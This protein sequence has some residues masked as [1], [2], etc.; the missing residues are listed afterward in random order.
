MASAAYDIAVIGAGPAGMAAALYARIKR[1]ETVVISKDVGGQML[2]GPAIG[3][4]LGFEAI[5]SAELIMRMRTQMEAHGPTVV[6]GNAATKVER[7]GRGFIV[8]AGHDT[9]QVKAVII[10]TG[11]VPRRL[12][13]PGERELVGKG[14]TYCT[15]CDGPLFK[16]KQVAV[17]GSGMS[18]IYAALHLLRIASHV[19]LLS[20]YALMGEPHL[21][22]DLGK[23]ANVTVIESAQVTSIN[24]DGK[25]ESV[26]IHYGDDTQEI[27]V[28]G[29]FVETGWKP[30]SD[31]IRGLK[32][33]KDQEIVIDKSH[34]TSVPGVFAAGD[35]TM[36]AE[37]QILIAAS[38]G[39]RSAMQAFRWLLDNRRL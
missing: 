4:Y 7:K 1:L 29:V 2:Y 22:G 34:M 38:E 28:D 35:V 13:V 36:V 33:N 15:T 26:T 23:A 3:N 37:K 25:V 39:A 19:F 5:P 21:I 18:A 24:G 32:L 27:K 10:A 8:S 30:V 16:G 20:D 17:V 11:K 12:G 6:E 9:Y 31:L 14:V